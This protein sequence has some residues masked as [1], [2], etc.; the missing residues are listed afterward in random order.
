ME[1]GNN[2][3]NGIALGKTQ[4]N[5]KQSDEKYVKTPF[6]LKIIYPLDFQSLSKLEHNELVK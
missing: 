1:I 6:D 5:L 3:V 4:Y 2:E